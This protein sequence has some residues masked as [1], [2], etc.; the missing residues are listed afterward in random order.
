M[1]THE[2]QIIF[3]QHNIA[4]YVNRIFFECKTKIY[5]E[6][7]NVETESRAVC[8]RGGA[9]FHLSSNF[10]TVRKYTFAF[11]KNVGCKRT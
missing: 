6:V 1:I 10:Y 5:E 9:E 8:L 2:K 11:S 4:H 7:S 3:Q